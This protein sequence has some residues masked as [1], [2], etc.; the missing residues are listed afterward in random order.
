MATASAKVD[1]LAPLQLLH[2]H[3]TAALCA[4]VFAGARVLER[5]RVW[6]L[7]RLAEFWTAVILRAPPSL[8]Q[9]LEEAG[10]GP[11]PRASSQ[12]FFARCQNLRFEFF[13]DLF[14]AF[15]GRVLAGRPAHFEGEHRSLYRRFGAVWIVDGSRLDAIA[16][17]LKILRDE[18]AVVLP[19]ALTAFYDLGRGVVRVLGFCADA[20]ASELHRAIGLLEKVPKGTLLVGDRLYANAVFFAAL[21]ARGLFG[22]VRYQRSLSLRGVKLLA[23][24]ALDGGRLI[25]RLVEAGSGQK[26]EV[27]Q[28]RYICWQKGRT[29]RE[30]L[31]NVLDP[32]RLSAAEALALYPSRWK[33]ERLFYDLKEVLNLHC[34]YAANVNAVAM[35]VYAAAIVHAALRVAQ[36]EI[37]RQVDVEPEQL[38]VAKLFPRVAAASAAAAYTQIGIAETLRLNR[39]LKLRTPNLR[40]FR[41]AATTLAAV[42]VEPR[43][44][45]RRHP[46]FCRARAR[47]KSITRVR[48][49]QD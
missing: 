4:Q 35:Q 48:G 25:D 39:G 30:L 34:F 2:A 19:G 12:G 3:L 20:A 11:Q 42:L 32:R 40:R 6:S 46:R 47:W 23:R 10:A 26:A 31:T 22:L 14:E 49:F 1:L 41:F 38:S 21:S 7:H 45:P 8:T 44:G 33:V 43:R 16:H 9:A 18:R 17:R 24:R 15:V 36:A 13:R 28:L 29:K 37:A 27:Q 5:Q